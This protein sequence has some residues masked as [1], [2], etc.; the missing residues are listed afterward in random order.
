MNEKKRL[1]P[2]MQAIIM[3]AGVSRRL[4]EYTKEVPKSMLSISGISPLELHFKSFLENGLNDA[5][6][7]VGYLKDKI[8]FAFGGNYSDV[9]IDY[10]YNEEY[11]ETG[12]GYS[13]YLGLQKAS[14]FPL[15][16]MDADIFYE[17]IVLKTIINA[18]P[19]TLLVCDHKCDTEAVKAFV[20]DDRIIK[21]SKEFPAGEEG[22]CSGE[23]VGVFKLSESAYNILVS[24]MKDQVENGI[25]S[26]EWEDAMNSLFEKV[27]VRPVFVDANW[28]EID[29]PEDL[30]RA[31][32]MFK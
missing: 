9:R 4:K 13:L 6:V 25:K 16:A 2:D 29:F 8:M 21:L 12:S 15:I 1:D 32:R 22:K 27:S 24:L 11:A 28:I 30:E 3:A 18:E 26:F 19:D 5:V 10:T 14:N 20:V 17:P 23:S 7:V 31:R